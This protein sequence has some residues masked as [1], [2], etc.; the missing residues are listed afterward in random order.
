M[1][2]FLLSAIRSKLTFLIGLFAVGAIV[3]L[4]TGGDAERPKTSERKNQELIE[5]AQRDIAEDA[6]AVDSAAQVA[7]AT[8]NLKVTGDWAR[9]R[10]KKLRIEDGS[11]TVLTGLPANAD[12]KKKAASLCETLIGG[13]PPMVEIE[14]WVFIFGRGLKPIRAD[15]CDTVFWREPAE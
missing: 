10:M 8:M 9:Y 11:L 15:E 14:D 5:G 1:G 3:L 13:D 12:S 2:A 4:I 7:T 6:T